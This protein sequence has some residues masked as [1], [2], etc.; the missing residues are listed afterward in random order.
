MK[1]GPFVGEETAILFLEVE[2]VVEVVE[3]VV[4]LMVEMGEVAV[5]ERRGLS[6]DE[7]FLGT[8]FAAPSPLSFLLF[9]CVFVS[10]SSVFF[11]F[12]FVF[13]GDTG[14]GAGVAGVLG[15]AGFF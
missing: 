13:L 2:T 1:E 9:K 4:K 6:Q 14:N 10:I 7:I 3:V 8:L 5:F 12:L 15:V 11:F